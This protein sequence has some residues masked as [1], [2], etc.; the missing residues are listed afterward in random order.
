MGCSRE[1]AF[2]ARFLAALPVFTGK[3]EPLDQLPAVAMRKLAENVLHL[4]GHNRIIHL[5]FRSPS[6][7]R[8]FVCSAWWHRES[9]GLVLLNKQPFHSLQPNPNA[10]I[11]TA[12]EETFRKGRAQ[13]PAKAWGGGGRGEIC[14]W[15]SENPWHIFGYRMKRKRW[16]VWP[17]GSLRSR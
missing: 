8:G 13:S 5:C 17:P 11:L 7:R 14:W 3:E 16:Q 2:K 9:G 1:Q 4:K 12:C 6:G 10:S 15:L